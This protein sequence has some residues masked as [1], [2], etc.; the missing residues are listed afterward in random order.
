MRR[1]MIDAKILDPKGNK[2]IKPP[3]FNGD[4]IVDDEV[5]M[6]VEECRWVWAIDGRKMFLPV[7]ARCYGVFRHHYVSIPRFIGKKIAKY[8]DIMAF[9]KIY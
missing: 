2:L 3:F 8:Q 1:S 9:G 5:T 6:I 4:A 7:M